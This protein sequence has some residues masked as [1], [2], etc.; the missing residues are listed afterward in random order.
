M[1]KLSFTIIL[2][3]SLNTFAQK[4]NSKIDEIIN[5]EMQE[6]RIPGL[7]LAIVQEGKI[8][9]SKSYGYAN[10][11]DNISVKNTTIFPINS[12]TKIFTGVSVLILSQVTLVL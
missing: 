8:V 3:L 2:F 11:Q 10:I 5:R 6:R 1:K 4:V 9:L 12:N 7:Q